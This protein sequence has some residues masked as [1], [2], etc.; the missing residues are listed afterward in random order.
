MD[1]QEYWKNKHVKY[2]LEDWINKPSIFAQYAIKYFPV[3]ASIL[4]L[5]GGQGQD[6]KYFSDE[7]FEVVCTDFSD[8]ALQIA[9]QKYPD[10]NYKI[11]DLHNN[12]PFPDNSFDVVYSNM[13]LHYFD[14]PTTEKLF[15]EINRVLKKGGILACLLN[16]MEDPEVKESKEIEPGLYETPSGLVKRFFDLDFLLQFTDSYFET[17]IADNKGETYKDKI[18]TLIRFV[19]K[20]K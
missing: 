2:A 10:L 1:V 16:T 18:K 12:F 9:K 7:G 3:G 11:H 17:I 13:A 6:S 19:G 15:R 4:E 20:K 14:L 8:S 5:G